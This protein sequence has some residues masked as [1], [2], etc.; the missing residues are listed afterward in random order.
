MRECVAAFLRPSEGA[1]VDISVQFFTKRPAVVFHA[2]TGPREQNEAK[3]RT[4]SKKNDEDKRRQTWQRH[5][6]SVA[7][8]AASQ[9]A[10]PKLLPTFDQ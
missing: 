7:R 5:S 9:K 6:I 1:V 2:T 3:A 8:D 4:H 10:R